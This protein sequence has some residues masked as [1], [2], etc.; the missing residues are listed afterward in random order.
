MADFKVKKGKNFFSGP[1]WN[2]F[3][4]RK[5][6]FNVKAIFWGDCKYRLTEN[7]DQINKLTGQSFKI[8]PWYDKVGKKFR[9]GHHKDSVRFG[10]RCTDGENIEIL[11]YAYINGLRKSKTL[12]FVEVDSWVYLN[13]KETNNYYTF[14]V[15]DGDENS[16]IAKFKKKGTKKGFL[17]LFINRLYPYFGGRIASPHNMTISLKYLK[18]FV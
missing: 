18:K 11:A 9:P 5:D 1:K 17:R 6:E 4:R 2:F 12:A 8:L 15:I 7:Y 14:K 3:G 16:S 13:F 10:W